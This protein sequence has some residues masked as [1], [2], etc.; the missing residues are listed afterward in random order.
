MIESPVSFHEIFTVSLAKT[1]FFWINESRLKKEFPEGIHIH[2][3]GN[4]NMR[5]HIDAKYVIDA[6]VRMDIHIQDRNAVLDIF[7]PHPPID[8]L[9][10]T[11]G[12]GDTGKKNGKTRNHHTRH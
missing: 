7:L 11:M 12:N 8:D 2:F 10:G 6:A 9:C 5:V 3:V 4:R 1:I